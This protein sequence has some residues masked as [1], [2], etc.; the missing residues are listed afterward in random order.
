VSGAVGPDSLRRLEKAA[1]VLSFGARS[2]SAGEETPMKFAT[3]S[4]AGYYELRSI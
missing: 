1:S 4:C 2:S 3:P